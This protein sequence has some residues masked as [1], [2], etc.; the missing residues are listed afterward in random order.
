[1]IRHYRNCQESD[2]KHTAL[3]EHVSISDSAIAR[4]RKVSA[5]LCGQ[6]VISHTAAEEL[7]GPPLLCA[8]HFADCL[9]PADLSVRLA[10]ADLSVRFA[11][12]EV[13]FLFRSGFFF[14]GSAILLSLLLSEA[15]LLRGLLASSAH[16]AGPEGLFLPCCCFFFFFFSCGGAT[17]LSLPLPKLKSLGR[18]QSDTRSA[19]YAPQRHQQER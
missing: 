8:T 18:L 5:Y 10:P 1:M 7:S 3:A 17:S 12:A 15:A 4:Q 14:G 2:A 6:W 9:V 13:L 16:F 11:E 19:Q